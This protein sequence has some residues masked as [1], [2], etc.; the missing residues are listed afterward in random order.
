MLGQSW[1]SLAYRNLKGFWVSGLNTLADE[2][3]VGKKVEGVVVDDIQ[4]I[5]RPRTWSEAHPERS[6]SQPRTL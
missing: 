5:R 1:T 2:R 6:L 3:K 4:T